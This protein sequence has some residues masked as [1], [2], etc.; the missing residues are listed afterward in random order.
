MSNLYCVTIKNERN[1][2][3]KRNGFGKQSGER[4]PDPVG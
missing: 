2:I 1:A 3:L 4:R